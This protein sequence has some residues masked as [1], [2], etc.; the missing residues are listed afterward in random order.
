MPPGTFEVVVGL[1]FA[2]IVLVLLFEPAYQA[3]RDNS[4]AVDVEAR[5]SADGVRVRLTRYPLTRSVVVRSVGI[6]REL[7]DELGLEIPDGFTFAQDLRWLAAEGRVPLGEEPVEIVFR[8]T[9]TPT[10]PVTGSVRIL[11]SYRP[12]LRRMQHYTV[13]PIHGPGD[14]DG[15]LP[16]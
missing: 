3:G 6:S 14:P 15:A 16:G 13:Q 5:R 1:A 12:G 9:R 7:S 11:S 8:A 2:A 4:G 10:V